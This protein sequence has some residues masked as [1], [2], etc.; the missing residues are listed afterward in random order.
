MWSGCVNMER[1]FKLFGVLFVLILSLSSLSSI[2]L[3]VVDATYIEGLIALDTVWTLTDSPFVLSNNVTIL[4]DVT[5]TIKPGVEVRSGGGFYIVVQ[6]RL[7]AEGKS[8]RMIKFTSNKL[9]PPQGDWGSMWFSGSESSL[10]YCIIEYGT[11]GATLENGSLTIEHS[12]IRNNLEKGIAI[13][14][15]NLFASDNEIS[16]NA[17]SGIHI[18]GGDQVTIQNNILNSNG[19]GIYLADH[20]DGEIHIERNTILLNKQNGIV[21][22]ADAYDNTNI[23]NNN[24]TANLKG[25]L[26]STNT[27]TYITRNYVWNNT[28]GILYA[29]GGNHEAHFND[30]YANS[31]GMNVTGD[32]KVDATY[33]YWGDRTGPYHEGLNPYAKGN[34]VNGDGVNL[35]FLFFLTAPKDYT[36]TKPNAILWSDKTL[37]S[38]NQTVT[39][40]G[41]DSYDDG[42]VDYF[43]FD[44][45]D[46]GKVHTTLPLF[47]YSYSIVGTYYANL[48]VIDDFNATSENVATTIVNVTDLTP[49]SVSVA[50]S[51]ENVNFNENVTV[52]AYVT[53]GV[54]PVENANVT[55]FSIKGGSFD[56]VSALTNSAG[57]IIATFTAP[58]VTAIT[59]IRI[60]ARAE[61]PGYAD[62][63]DFKYV[64]VVPPLIVQVAAEDPVV[65][66]EAGTIVNVDVSLGPGR[67]VKDTL[68][69]L[70]SDYGDVTPSSNLT[71]TNGRTRFTFIAPQTLSQL[72]TTLTATAMKMEY[73]EGNG[74]ATITVEPRI[75]TIIATPSQPIIISGD[76]STIAVHVTSDGT[77]ISN[78]TLAATTD[79]GEVS[80]QSMLT[81]A[82]G[83]GSFA[84]TVSVPSVDEEIMATISFFASKDGYGGNV[85]Q[86]NVEVVPKM[87]AVQIT[88]QPNATYSEATV[89][90]TAHVVYTHDMTPVSDVNVTIMSSSGGNF[91]RDS[92]LTDVNGEVAFVFQAPQTNEQ[93]DINISAL[94]SKSGYVSGQ[95]YTTI[96]VTP[97]ILSIQINATSEAVA[98]G[99]AL[100]IKVYA[101]RNSTAVPNVSVFMTTNYGNFSIANGVTDS[102]GQCTFIFNAPQTEIQLTATINATVSKNGYVTAENQTRINIMPTASVGGGGSLA[103]TTILLAGIPIIAVVIGVVLVKLKVLSFSVKE[104]ET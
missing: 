82:A 9:N 80:P 88:T 101:T 99:D 12:F 53:D 81:D 51:N 86:A 85:V 47:E 73:A 42:R 15:G 79:I 31:A 33:N 57:Q 62:G 92:G 44:F 30:I 41:T 22:A 2:S 29:D 100:V 34:P 10:T 21:L 25:F 65:K 87:L 14:S 84:F 91:S 6:G 93:T 18:S 48:V 45:N 90:L 46:T 70:S 4:P 83:I 16:N 64:R 77:P 37:I 68:V 67:P 74:Q 98:S 3:R 8:D 89:N 19:D 54:S 13:M 60:V 40:I 28:I 11:N 104:E 7:I 78:A 39:F 71:D 52:T 58:N 95:N 36:N 49:L 55:L 50:L 59:D 102:N 72:V 17:E 75:L 56:T 66:S 5:L 35:D 61:M 94:A 26:I 32:A 27:S 20:L 97:A 96:T 76:T 1:Q 103:L 38:P 69:I 63:S 23:L 43:T 24:V